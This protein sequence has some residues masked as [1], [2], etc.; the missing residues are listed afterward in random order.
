MPRPCVRLILGL[1]FSAL[2]APSAAWALECH[3]PESSVW[4]VGQDAAKDIAYGDAGRRGAT[5]AQGVL[6]TVEEVVGALQTTHELLSGALEESLRADEEIDVSPFHSDW[7]QESL[8]DCVE[9]H[10][11]AIKSLDFAMPDTARFWPTLAEPWDKMAHCRA[12]T[13]L[14]DGAK[15][16]AAMVRSID[17]QV[18]WV[19][20]LDTHYEGASRAS[21]A[22]GRGFLEWGESGLLGT[23]WMAMAVGANMLFYHD[24][25]PTKISNLQ[26]MARQKIKAAEKTK[27]ML[28]IE[29]KKLDEAAGGLWRHY[30][31]DIC[32]PDST[33]SL[34]DLD[35]A[36]SDLVDEQDR[37][38]D[39]QRGDYDQ[40]VDPSK[41]AAGLGGFRAESQD[42]I[43]ASSQ[44]MQQEVLRGIEDSFRQGAA[45]QAG[46][47]Q[48]ASARSRAEQACGNDR[49][50]HC[51]VSWYG[52]GVDPINAGIAQCGN[53]AQQYRDLDDWCRNIGNSE[54]WC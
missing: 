10:H 19:R 17:E 26:E 24:E 28:Q 25:L 36:L 29:Q 18:G 43:G 47:A 38:A 46:K 12:Y 3:V 22:L 15:A 8:E 4:S 33:E 48:S 31:A 40:L 37:Q 50:S 34:D 20:N 49:Y 11:G 51:C 5:D 45:R 1:V 16:V 41:A 23:D 2:A 27:T 7:A 53:W 13:K 54:P 52:D 32:T 9:R 42:T 44:R 39:A 30:G 35:Q 14:D 6:E 21:V